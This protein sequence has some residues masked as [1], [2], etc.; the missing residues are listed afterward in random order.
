MC[1][2]RGGKGSRHPINLLRERCLT[3]QGRL[4]PFVALVYERGQQSH[5]TLRKRIGCLTLDGPCAADRRLL[6]TTTA[7]GGGWLQRRRRGGQRHGAGGWE[8]EADT[9]SQVIR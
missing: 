7:A 6:A 5:Q 4:H 2:V 8:E 1:S 9:R 3:V